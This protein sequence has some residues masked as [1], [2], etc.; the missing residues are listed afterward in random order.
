MA[1]IALAGAIGLLDV[2]LPFLQHVYHKRA[3]PDIN[4]VKELLNTMRSF[5]KD[6]EGREETEGWKDRV[7]KVRNLAYETEVA[8]DEFMFD[9]TGNSHHHRLTTFLHNARHSF[10]DIKR[11]NRLSSQLKDIKAKINNIKDTDAFRCCNSA[12]TSSFNVEEIPPE[13]YPISRDDHLVGINRRIGK[14]CSLILNNESRYAVISVFGGPGTG[15]TTLIHEV[16]K[17]VKED[18][19][20]CAWV[21]VPRSFKQLLENICKDMG[22][23]VCQGMDGRQMLIQHV[24]QKRYIF[25][26]D[27]I[28]NE[29]E[30]HYIESLLPF[31][32]KG[33]RIII[34]TCKRNLAS[35]CASSQD[36]IYDLNINPL[37]WQEA[38]ELFYRKAFPSGKPPSPLVDW[39]EK[40]V[41]RCERLPH[42]I[43]A[44]GNILSNKPSTIME[45][46]NV[47]DSLEFEP[48]SSIGHTYIKKLVQSYFHLLPNLKSYHSVTRGRLVRLWIA[49]GFIGAKAGKNLEQVADEYLDELSCRVYNL[50]D[51]F[52]TIV[53]GPETRL[54][55]NIPRR[56]SLHNL[57]P[58]I[59]QTKGFP[60]VRTFSV[61]GVGNR[62]E[63]MAEDLFS[64]FKLLR[65]LDLENAAL[66]H[67]PQE[68]VNLILLRYLSLRNTAIKLVPKSIKKLQNLMIFDLRETFVTELPKEICELHKL[69]YLLVSCVEASLGIGH[70]TLLQKL[71]LIKAN[72]KKQSIVKELGN[73]IELRKLGITEL[74]KEDG[75]DLCASIEKME[76]LTS[77][78]VES[79][80]MEEDLDLNYVRK[81][82]E[83]INRVF[84]GGR[85]HYIPKWICSLDN[86]SKIK[87]KLSKLEN[88]PLE[89]LQD[90][91][92]LKELHLYDAYNGKELVFEAERFLEL[93][94][95]VIEQF[96]QLCMVV[97]QETAVPKLQKLNIRNC[98]CLKSLCISQS[99]L[100][101][102]EERHV[103]GCLNQ[104]LPME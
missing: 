29:D 25:V 26:F 93:R 91:P 73:L 46:K 104:G 89:S 6:T 88:S 68:V 82:P 4:E 84:L 102:L 81:S 51:N 85:L 96:S 47:H 74:M 9:V 7:Q 34:S 50:N 44:V 19:E 76:H 13:A 16:Y 62:L 45:F 49:E 31:N 23:H 72:N 64:K 98:D 41:K 36:Y 55:E 10:T 5:L 66:Q 103:P 94:M 70:L 79:V 30:W 33:S 28:W 32:N 54:G 97:F 61:F 24:Q 35:I 21:P 15:K 11:I 12:V 99:I 48:G 59:S 22:L 67:F 95:L 8:I 58:C 86:L 37:T 87:L 43:V 18:F 69:L 71:S 60:N 80:S 2:V 27:G 38:W 40:I 20:C 52:Y 75:K 77:L 42:A 101:R 1:E 100:N 90:L 83:L 39:S 63:S 56:L 14:I 65:V 78:Y 3:S 53:R 92:S 17:L 57:S